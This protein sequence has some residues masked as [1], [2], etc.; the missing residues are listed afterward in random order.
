MNKRGDVPVMI[1][2][3]GVIAI[4]GLAIFSFITFKQSSDK[5]SLEKGLYLFEQVYSDLEKFEFYRQVIGQDKADEM[6]K[7]LR[8]VEDNIVIEKE[9]EGVG[10]RYEKKLS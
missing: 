5:N 2:V 9:D 1:L 6:V 3:I 8:V 10:I 7:D 4:C